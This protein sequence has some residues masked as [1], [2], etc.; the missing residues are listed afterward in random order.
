MIRFIMVVVCLLILGQTDMAGAGQTTAKKTSNTSQ[1]KTNDKD[2]PVKEPFFAIIMIQ[3]PNADAKLPAKVEFKPV[4]Q[5]LV[6]QFG[7]QLRDEQTRAMKNWQQQRAA[8]MKNKAN[9]GKTFSTPRPIPARTR[10]VA[11]N[12]KGAE[13]VQKKL[14]E[15]NKQ[16]EAETKA[17]AAKDQ[18]S[19]KPAKPTAKPA[20]PTVGPVAPVH[21]PKPATKV[22][23][24][25]PVQPNPATPNDD[26]PPP[27]DDD[28]EA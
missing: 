10:L 5:R 25:P 24:Q 17:A 19:T 22:Q 21:K 12:L 16:L 28:P 13:A 3:T 7:K 4:E 6:N 9:R 2:Q 26:T 20:T 14:E 1:K 15:L 11:N 27:M 8:F 18:D 23:P